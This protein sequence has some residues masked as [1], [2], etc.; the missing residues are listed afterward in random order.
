MGLFQYEVKISN[1]TVACADG[2]MASRRVAY[3]IILEILGRQGE[4]DAIVEPD[5]K[6][7]LGQIVLDRL[8]LIPDAKK[9]VLGPRS[10]SPDTPL[11][12]I[13]GEREEGK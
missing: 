4:F 12:E 3:G 5:G 10:E 13:F 6:I 1:P 9:G 8:D 2:R 11:I 7:L